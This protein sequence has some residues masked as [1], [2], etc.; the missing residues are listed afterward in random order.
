VGDVAEEL[1]RHAPD[2]LSAEAHA[3][4]ERLRTATEPLPTDLGLTKLVVWAEARFGIAP[5]RRSTP[6]S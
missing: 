5:A 3:L 2:R 1:F 4:N 6:R